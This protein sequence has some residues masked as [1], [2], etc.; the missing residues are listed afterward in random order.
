MNISG[1]NISEYEK[2]RATVSQRVVEVREEEGEGSGGRRHIMAGREEGHL[3]LQ[4]RG[5]RQTVTAK[6][7]GSWPGRRIRAHLPTCAGTDSVKENMAEV[8]L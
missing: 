5:R 7:M 4:Q 3:R 6:L 2:G 1:M 8:P